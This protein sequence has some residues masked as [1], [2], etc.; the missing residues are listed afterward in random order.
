MEIKQY[1]VS[2]IV[3]SPGRQQEEQW[4]IIEPR[5]IAFWKSAA[6]KLAQRNYSHND[7]TVEVRLDWTSLVRKLVRD[8]NLDLPLRT[9]KPPVADWYAK[10]SKPLHLK[11]TCKI[12]GANEQSAHPWYREFFVEYFLYEIFTISNLALPGSGE[13]LNFEVQTDHKGF[14]QRLGLSAFYF[15]EWMIKT[16]QGKGLPAKILD[17]DQTIDWFKS[18]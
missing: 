8:F 18:R 2:I 10:M 13:F 11:A 15:S 12:T 7:C 4:E 16:T 17:I 3:R 6:T 5:E 1:E 9:G 14:D